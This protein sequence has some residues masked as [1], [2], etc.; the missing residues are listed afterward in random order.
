MALEMLA[1]MSADVNIP[2]IFKQLALERRIITES[3]FECSP[4]GD[5]SLE[6]FP[7]ESSL[8]IGAHRFSKVKFYTD[9]TSLSDSLSPPVRRRSSLSLLQKYLS[10]SD[11]VP[12][13]STANALLNTATVF[14]QNDC[15]ANGTPE[16]AALSPPMVA[17]FSEN[18]HVGSSIRDILAKN[19]A[20]MQ[21][22]NAAP[23]NPTNIKGS[24]AHLTPKPKGVYF[25]LDEDGP[26]LFV[27]PSNGIIERLPMLQGDRTVMFSFLPREE[28][29]AGVI[30]NSERIT[31][32]IKCSCVALSEAIRL[33]TRDLPLQPF[34]QDQRPKLTEFSRIAYKEVTF[35]FRPPTI[36]SDENMIKVTRGNYSS[37]SAH[38][39][40]IGNGDGAVSDAAVNSPST[41]GNIKLPNKR[42][43]KKTLAEKIK[44]ESLIEETAAIIAT[45]DV[46]KPDPFLSN[47]PTVEA[48]QG[49]P[50]VQMHPKF[51]PIKKRKYMNV[52]NSSGMEKVNSNAA[53][54]LAD[55]SNVTSPFPQ[56]NE[57]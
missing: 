52:S 23:A 53:T 40:V 9:T 18:D 12:K 20:L 32:A 15:V 51:A 33:W 38:L 35:P 49:K 45:T 30:D 26:N 13:Q 37:V 42:G 44:A 4:L 25:R 57:E 34:V 50:L 29:S 48:V 21:L 17:A 1:N 41:I 31:M 14:S 19:T 7:G 55:S 8:F 36:L 10:S 24:S 11:P 22:I 5:E 27:L 6:I 16:G 56:I 3:L 47:Q 28:L 46:V 54:T 2:N 43:K 39:N